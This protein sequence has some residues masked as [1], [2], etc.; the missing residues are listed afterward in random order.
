MRL[1]AFD[2]SITGPAACVWDD[3]EPF[4]F[5]TCRFHFLTSRKKWATRIAPNIHGTL[6]PEV[7]GTDERRFDWI[8]D[9]AM[10]CASGATVAAIEGYA[11]GA[12]G[13]VFNLAENTGLLKHKLH[14]AGIPIH[15][16]EPTKVKKI[17][18]GMGNASKER[19]C[20]AFTAETGIDMKALFGQSG[21]LGSPVTDVVDAYF[22]AKAFLAVSR[23]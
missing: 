21:D 13:R 20:D 22:V 19:M 15:V 7:R 10:E 8:S 23:A 17:G 16:V 11:F 1:V 9:W 2:Y 4:G 5:P 14:R 3:S 12:R 6:F 18:S